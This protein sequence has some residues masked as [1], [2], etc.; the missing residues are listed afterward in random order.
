MTNPSSATRTKSG[1][2]A[3]FHA[4]PVAWNAFVEHIGT[5]KKTSD[6]E[7]LFILAYNK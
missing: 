6:S 3:F 1:E 4:D 7:H 5:Q 2:R